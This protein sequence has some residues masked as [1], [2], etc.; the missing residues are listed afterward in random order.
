MA[1]KAPRADCVVSNPWYRV[2][3]IMLIMDVGKSKAYEIINTLQDELVN[4]KI[5][6]KNR[7]YAKPPAGRIRKDYFCEAYM[8]NPDECDALIA[9][10]QFA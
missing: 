2:E 9:Q 10:Q 6:G 3:D 4:T 7:C 5:P 8:L 1:L